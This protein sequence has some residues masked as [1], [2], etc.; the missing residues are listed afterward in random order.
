MVPPP[1]GL[2]IV[3]WQLALYLERAGYEVATAEDGFSLPPAPAGAPVPEGPRA[4]V[5]HSGV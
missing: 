2:F 3:S 4:P 5:L 1:P